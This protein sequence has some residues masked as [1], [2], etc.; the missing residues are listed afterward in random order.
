MN[1]QEKVIETLNDLIRINHDRVEGYEKAAHEIS[2]PT[3]VEIKSLFYQMAEESR[4]YITDLTHAVIR[5]GGTPANDTTTSGKIYRM[6][7]DVKVSFTG[8]DLKA[9]LSSCEFGEDAAQRAYDDAMNAEV[10]LPADVAALISN[11]QQLLKTSHDKIK[12][13]RDELKVSTLS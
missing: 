9:I 5:F 7:M 1:I 13:Y 2:D 10:K 12:R 11:Q 8:D 4:I 6:W 3:Q